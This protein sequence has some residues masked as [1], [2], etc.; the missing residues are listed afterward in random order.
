M[1]F[2]FFTFFVAYSITFSEKHHKT[3]S[4]ASQVKILPFGSWSTRLPPDVL[5]LLSSWSCVCVQK[6]REWELYASMAPLTFLRK[7]AEVDEGAFFTRKKWTSRSVAKISSLK[8]NVQKWM[9]VEQNA[10]TLQKGPFLQGRNEDRDLWRNFSVWTKCE[11]VVES[12]AKC[13]EFVK[14]SFFTRKKW[15]SRSGS[16]V[17]SLEK[18][19]ESWKVLKKSAR[20]LKERPIFTT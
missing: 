8:I 6:Y 7:L 1:R 3:G 16:K 17:S 11:K 10:R 12:W 9:R 19:R 2:V 14:G 20:E 13:V 18:V 15:T 5:K 4:F